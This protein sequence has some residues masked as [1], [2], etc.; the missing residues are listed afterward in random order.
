M[1]KIFLSALFVAGIGMMTAQQTTD[2]KT[3]Q[4]KEWKKDTVKM[5]EK[6]WDSMKKE[7]NLTPEQEDQ[8]KALHEKH[9]GEMKAMKSQE[10]AAKKSQRAERMQQRDSEMKSILTPEQYGKWQ[11]MKKTKMRKKYD[12]MKKMPAMK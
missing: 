2:Q 6:K 12:T 9:R 11:E 7:L 3:A 10:R 5:H 8:I 4:Q 1:K